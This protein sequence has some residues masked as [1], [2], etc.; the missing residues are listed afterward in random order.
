MNDPLNITR[1]EYVSCRNCGLLLAYVQSVKG[2]LI[3]ALT[4]FLISLKS[5]FTPIR[6]L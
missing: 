2:Q 6:Q 4:L 3:G 5:G 1:I